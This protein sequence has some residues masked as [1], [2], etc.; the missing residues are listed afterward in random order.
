MVAIAHGGLGHD[1]APTWQPDRRHTLH[2]TG[3]R[4]AHDSLLSLFGA[5]CF[6]TEIESEGHAGCFV[7][8]DLTCCTALY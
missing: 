1:P 3:P 4:Q 7:G 5:V 6:R 8:A 2:M